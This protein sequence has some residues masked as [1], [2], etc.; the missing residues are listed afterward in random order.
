M[1]GG[2]KALY[3]VRFDYLQKYVNLNVIYY[4]NEMWQQI[5]LIQRRRDC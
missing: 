3:S 5:I 1:K 2:E 4:N